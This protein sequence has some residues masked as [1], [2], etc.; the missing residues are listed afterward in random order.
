MPTRSSDRRGTRSAFSASARAT[1]RGLVIGVVIAAAG[2]AALLAVGRAGWLAGPAPS[3]LGLADGRLAAPSLTPNSVSSQARQWPGHPRRDEAH[4]DPL[5]APDPAAWRQLRALLDAA[6]GTRILQREPSYL[7]V[8]FHTR[9]LGF[10]DD[11]EFWW[12]EAAGVV[13]VRSASRLGR[14]DL[15]AN[16]QRIELLRAALAAPR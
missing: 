11:A 6:P 12:D 1:A 4:I 10:V 14:H 5:P 3:G 2:A 13:H 9:W 7:R 16:R 15:G 8:E